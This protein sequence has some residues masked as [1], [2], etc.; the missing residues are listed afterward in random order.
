MLGV[1]CALDPEEELE[2]LLEPVLA[3]DA[4]LEGDAELE[5]DA[6]LDVVPVDDDFA[7]VVDSLPAAS[8]ALALSREDE[9]AMRRTPDNTIPPTD[10]LD[11]VH[12]VRARPLSRA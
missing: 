8:R 7:P 4:E 6:A 11:I 1:A 10:R 5:L 9:Q 2:V 12:L 3:F